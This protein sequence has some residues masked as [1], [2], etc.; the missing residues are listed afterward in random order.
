M[1]ELVLTL[2][3]PAQLG[4]MARRDNVLPTMEHIPGSVIRGALAAVWLARNGISQPGTP[5]REEFLALF[6][7]GV[8]FGALLRPG[9]E[10]MSL[11]VVG[12]KYEPQDNCQV[13]DY[14]R[15][16]G[17]Q[18][19]PQC[20]DCGSPLEQRRGLTASREKPRRRTSVAIGLSLIHI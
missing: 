4:S 14:D 18:P 10:Y 3:Q 7:G 13:I 16:A 2:R 17:Q 19:P 8:R 20:P 1:S 5:E 12:H 11:A 6:E 9:M 15:A